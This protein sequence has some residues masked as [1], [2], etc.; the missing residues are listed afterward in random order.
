MGR[1]HPDEAAREAGE[2]SRG[3]RMV[4]GKSEFLKVSRSASSISSNILLL[5][6]DLFFFRIKC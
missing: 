5:D 2:V 4:A 1:R 6:I 3:A